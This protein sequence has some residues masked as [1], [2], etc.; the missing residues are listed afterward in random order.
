MRPSFTGWPSSVTS[1]VIIPVGGSLAQP[2]QS[3]RAKSSA[4][5]PTFLRSIAEIISPTFELEIAKRF[6]AVHA[7]ERLPRGEGNVVRYKADRAVAEGG[8]DAARMPAADCL[9][10]ICAGVA[11]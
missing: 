1:P 4:Q 7:A 9:L 2:A 8:V 10:P 6:A 5:T 11:G 3:T